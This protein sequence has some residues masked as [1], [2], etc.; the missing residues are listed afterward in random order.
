M[1]SSSLDIDTLTLNFT[2]SISQ[3]LHISSDWKP[4]VDV[5]A[6]FTLDGKIRPNEMSS[7]LAMT[8]L[9][10]V[11]RVSDHAVLPNLLSWQLS[12]SDSST[13]SAMVPALFKTDIGTNISSSMPFSLS[14]IKSANSLAVRATSL[15]VEFCLN[16]PC[17]IELVKLALYVVDSEALIAKVDENLQEMVRLYEQG[18]KRALKRAYMI[19]QRLE[20]EAAKTVSGKSIAKVHHATGSSTGAPD[21]RI[22]ISVELHAPKF[23]IPQDCSKDSL[24]CL[25]LDLGHMS[26]QGVVSQGVTNTMSWK[27][28]FSEMSADMP[29]AISDMYVGKIDDQL[30]E[31]TAE[32]LRQI[33]SSRELQS[34]DLDGN[35]RQHD[36]LQNYLIRPFGVKLAVEVRLVY[37]N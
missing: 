18:R 37:I 30:S 33:L 36:K 19:K 5:N 15:P 21:L 2:A 32:C 27:V 13:S 35:V 26:L 17:I 20:S 34:T 24:G 28:A 3:T 23:I 31:Q 6:S 7:T 29:Y 8:N 9:I 11:D 16:K 22:E 25:R 4:V 1:Q 14:I 10:V 12:S